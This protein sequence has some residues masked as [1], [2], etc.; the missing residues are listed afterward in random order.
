MCVCVA[1]K[2]G[3]EKESTENGEDEQGALC[4]PGK[5]KNRAPPRAALLRSYLM[6]I[7]LSQLTS[8]PLY[9]SP[10]FSSTS[11][12]WPA[13]VRSKESGSIDRDRGRASAWSWT[14]GLSC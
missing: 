8:S 2:T 6:F 3:N 9:V 11:I 5:K 4:V 13:A 1:R 7:Q 12:G 10:F 14:R